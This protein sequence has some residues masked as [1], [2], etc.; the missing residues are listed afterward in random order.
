MSNN[1]FIRKNNEDSINIV[2]GINNIT[3]YCVY[4]KHRRKL[5]ELYSTIRIDST[6][7]LC[8]II[9]KAKN[10]GLEVK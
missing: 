2:Y 3:I 9:T 4:K 7:D 10:N 1:Y 6:D 5:L 8:R